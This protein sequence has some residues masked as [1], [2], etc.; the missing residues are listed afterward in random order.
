MNIDRTQSYARYD[1]NQGFPAPRIGGITVKAI[2]DWKKAPHPMGSQAGGK[3]AKLL[4]PSEGPR[5]AELFLAGHV[6]GFIEP[7]MHRA[8]QNP[9]KGPAPPPSGGRRAEP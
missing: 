8:W 1:E 2:E 4:Q 3:G 9:R 7:H 5:V 6:G